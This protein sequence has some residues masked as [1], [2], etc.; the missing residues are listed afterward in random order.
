LPDVAGPGRQLAIGL[1]GW[2]THLGTSVLM[3]GGPGG[4][5]TILIFAP[6]VAA[7]A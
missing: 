5:S 2:A 3:T 1:P 7:I 4:D 6:F